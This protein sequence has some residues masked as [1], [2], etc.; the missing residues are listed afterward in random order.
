[1]KPEK[2]SAVLTSVVEPIDGPSGLP[3]DSKISKVGKGLCKGTKLTG[4]LRRIRICTPAVVVS[5]G[6]PSWMEILP[7]IGF[8]D[9]KVWCQD[10]VLLSNYYDNLLN[11]NSIFHKLHDLSHIS[12][13]RQ[14]MLFVSGSRSFVKRTEVQFRHLWIWAAILEDGS[15]GK[16]EK[17]EKL[18]RFNWKRLR[19]TQVGGVTDGSYWVGCNSLC[20]LYPAW[21]PTSGV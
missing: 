9:I 4:V 8:S 21:T 1:V 17:V 5:K 7:A 16:W 20:P 3:I 2:P 19:H 10:P 15:T 14:P 13:F 11:D 6:W 18:K 12:N